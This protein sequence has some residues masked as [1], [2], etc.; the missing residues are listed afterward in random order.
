MDNGAGRILGFIG[1]VVAVLATA[2]ILS[3]VC[4]IAA[5]TAT[6]RT[7]AIAIVWSCFAVQLVLL[8]VAVRMAM[9]IVQ[10]DRRRHA[11]EGRTQHLAEI[12]LMS[13]GL[14]H[15][16]RNQLHALQTRVSLLRKALAGNESALAR[17]DKLDE[18]ADGMEQL[19]TDFLTLARPAKD[20][21]EQLDPAEVIREVVDFERLDLDRS[22]IQV[23]LEL[24]NGLRLLVDRGKLKRALLNIVVNARQAMPNG[25]ELRIRCVQERNSIRIEISD[26]GEGI[27][28]DVLPRIFDS[29]FTTKSQG[30]G[31]G[32]AVV[33]RTIEDFGGQVNCTSTVG[34]G[35]TITITLPDGSRRAASIA[36]EVTR[37]RTYEPVLAGGVRP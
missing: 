19:L 10:G 7:I 32:L 37:H 34:K 1:L 25:G 8:A 12:A 36:R 28:A 31:L 29:Y 30:S 15:E 2:A 24:Q 35:T 26:N 4:L 23:A 20:E 14:A 6:L 33:R 11:A 22:A 17:V 21:L 9:R 13:G 3:T 18:I 5:S 16:V 27:P